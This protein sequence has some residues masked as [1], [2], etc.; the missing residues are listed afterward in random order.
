MTNPLVHRMAI[1]PFKLAEMQHVAR[2]HVHKLRQYLLVA[3]IFLLTACTSLLPANYPPRNTNIGA[4]KAWQMPLHREPGQVQL[5]L[6]IPRHGMT[7]IALSTTPSLGE[8]PISL[9]LSG[10]D[11]S[12]GPEAQIKFYTSDTE[13]RFKYFRTPLQWDEELIIAI[14]WD[15][16]ALTS[17]SVNQETLSVQALK[18]F[19]EIKVSNSNEAV[20]IQELHYMP[21]Q[22]TNTTS[23]TQ[24]QPE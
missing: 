10:Y 1:K 3:P 22:K 19:N 18:K 17:V 15:K 11:C 14:S 13:S 24:G 4:T 9:S 12:T 21:L 5:K 7:L 2:A 16:N 23:S 6:Q 20:T 8:S